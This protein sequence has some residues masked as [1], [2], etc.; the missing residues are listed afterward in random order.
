LKKALL[1]SITFACLSLLS[2]ILF[3]AQDDAWLLLQKASQAA[4]ELNYKGIFVYQSGSTSKS[5][6]LTHMNYGQGEYA[7]MVVLDGAPREVLS[8]GS[9]V[10]IFN[11]KN[12]KIMIEKKRGQNMFPA[13]LP[14]NME[15]IKTSYQA[16]YAS[17]ERIGGRDAYVINLTPRDQMRYG[18]RFWVDKEFGLLLKVTTLNEHGEALEQISFSQ[19]TWM[20]G[21]NIDWFKPKFDPSKAY[22][23]D[24]DQPTKASASEM[25]CDISQLP[26][27]FRKV[28][29]V[30]QTVK[31]KALPVIQMIFSDGLASISVFVEPLTK[32]VR[33]KIGHTVVGAT[34]F[35]AS[36]NEGHQVMVIGEVPEAA[37][38]KF[39][40]AISFKNKKANF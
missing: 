16:Q 9:D 8:Q 20:D 28:D 6:Q 18:Y 7:R 32:G 40:S 25:D 13:L 36:V 29:Q 10:V 19:L 21:Q 12:E 4:R 2:G 17:V 15:A 38:S 14:S 39:A 11:P 23:M 31:G 24:Q 30:K 26:A 22:V 33:P 3:A 5:V 34:N 1:I 27:G 35:Y 37:V